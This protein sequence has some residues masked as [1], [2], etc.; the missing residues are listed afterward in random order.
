MNKT[1]MC[2][3]FIII[4]TWTQ[5]NQAP[6]TTSPDTKKEDVSNIENASIKRGN[7]TASLDTVITREIESALA[8]PYRFIRTGRL[9][10]FLNLLKNNINIDIQVIPP[11]SLR[12]ENINST[13]FRRNYYD[14]CILNTI[15]YAQTRK[16]NKDVAKKSLFNAALIAFNNLDRP[17]LALSMYELAEASGYKNA[18]EPVKMIQHY[19]EHDLPHTRLLKILWRSKTEKEKLD[20]ANQLEGILNKNP[21]TMLKLKFSKQIGD[22][23]YSMEKYGPMMKWYRKAAAV[24]SNIVRD[25]PVGYRMNIG[26][27]VMLRQKQIYAIYAVYVIIIILLLLSIY[28][29]SDF[30][31][32]LFLRRIII[33][34]PVFLVIAVITLLFDFALT[35]GSIEAVLSESD[36]S[37]PKPIIPFSVFDISFIKGLMIILILGSLPILISI[38]YTSFKKQI[39][40]ILVIII[41]FLTVV[42]TWSHFILLKVF[43]NKLNK[44]AATSNSHIYFDGELEKML[45]DNPKKVLKTKPDLLSSGNKDLNHFIKEKKPELLKENE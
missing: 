43:D 37:V 19:I 24:D 41:I 3:L 18:S 31:T 28:W 6:W 9:E 27:K 39:S 35:S 13:K 16:T 33:C 42:S 17:K 45:V 12:D 36:V 5:E 15:K 20:Y 14:R 4:I 2:L 22:V 23:Y 8:E 32:A 40:K 38:F 7:E 26:K 11:D 1:T 21:D 34:I 44:R 30:R 10:K 29:S 25:T